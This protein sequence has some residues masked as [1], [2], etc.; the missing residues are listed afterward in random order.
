MNIAD[1]Q[2]NWDQFGKRDPFWAILTWRH[3]KGNKW[4][5]DDFFETGVQEIGD[6]M[7]SVEALGLPLV[8]HRALDFG[9]GAG[10]LTQALALHFDEVVGIDIAPSMVELARRYNRHEDRC[11]Y[12]LNEADDLALFVDNSFDFIY[13][14]IT[15]QH[16]E[17]GYSKN[18]IR[19]FIRLLAPHGLV[20]FQLPS[21]PVIHWRRRLV[22][23]FRRAVT[24]PLNVYRRFR[25]GYWPVMEA[26]GIPR[27][28]LL[29]LLDE[30]A[31]RI[32]HVQQDNSGG[33]DWIS[34]RYYATKEV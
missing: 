33:D 12:F 20:V 27:S 31:A 5:A 7:R 28:E 6:V 14:S 18:Y 26:Y 25:H 23:A 9:S 21:E 8:M 3:K 22:R 24:T 30:N 10:R 2:K 4:K 32:V 17:P 13:S 1:L 11:A 29:T 19:E 16:M 15:L 34:Y